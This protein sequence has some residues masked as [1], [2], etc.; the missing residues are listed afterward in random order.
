MPTSP[1][2]I[3]SRFSLDAI[4]QLATGHALDSLIQPGL[5][6]ATVS[7][8][9]EPSLAKLSTAF[10]WI[11]LPWLAEWFPWRTLTLLRNENHAL[12]LY[13][14]G[15]IKQARSTVSEKQEYQHLLS[16]VLA[17]AEVSDEEAANHLMTTLLAGVG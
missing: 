16:A 11:F 6:P 10:T 4:A 12:F 14:C 17:S 3:C 2:S 5:V 9:T 13:C 7:S 15:V 8:I 1:A